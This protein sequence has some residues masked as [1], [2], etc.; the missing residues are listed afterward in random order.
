MDI[1]KLHTLI[2]KQKYSE[3]AFELS[4]EIFDSNE[5]KDIHKDELLIYKHALFIC[6]ALKHQI[7][8]DASKEEIELWSKNFI[9]RNI[10][11]VLHSEITYPSEFES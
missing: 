10:N 4:K 11:L 7:K 9:K 1:D 5:L 2:Q 6:P 8:A 3:L